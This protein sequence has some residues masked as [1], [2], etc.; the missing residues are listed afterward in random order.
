MEKVHDYAEEALVHDELTALRVKKDKKHH[1]DK[2]DDKDDIDDFPPP[3]KGRRRVN[4]RRRVKG[5]DRVNGSDHVEEGEVSVPAI[6]G[7]SRHTDS[8]AL[9]S[10]DGDFAAV[11]P[12][13]SPTPRFGG[14]SSFCCRSL[15]VLTPLDV[16]RRNTAV[17]PS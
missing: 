12:P 4:R 5:V 14:E 3:S 6:A 17:L 9:L 1:D 13:Y 8:N 7:P 10:N 16:E 15:H 11:P 2:K